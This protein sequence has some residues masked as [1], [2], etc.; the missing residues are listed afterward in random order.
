[1]YIDYMKIGKRLELSDSD[2]IYDSGSQLRHVVSCIYKPYIIH[3]G[4]QRVVGM[5]NRICKAIFPLFNSMYN[6]FTSES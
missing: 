1:M 4:M 2:P 3:P 5:R 6:A